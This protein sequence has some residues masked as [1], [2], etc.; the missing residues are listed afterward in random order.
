MKSKSTAV[1]LAFFLGGIGIHRFYLGQ[2]I[3]GILY[4]L[5]CW[6]FIP[7]IISVIDFFAFLFMSESRFNYK[8]NLRTG[9]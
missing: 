6:T 4:L 1:L 7:V 5:F 8:Y 2:N 9:F 3:M